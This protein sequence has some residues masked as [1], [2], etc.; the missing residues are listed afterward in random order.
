MQGVYMIAN[1]KG[2][3]LHLDYERLVW[4]TT[5]PG[6]DPMT[7]P[8]RKNAADNLQRRIRIQAYGQNSGSDRMYILQDMRCTPGYDNGYDGYNM[9]ASGQVNIY[10][11]EACGS[12]EVS[13]SNHIDSM[14]IGFCAGPDTT[15]TLRFTSLIGESLYIKDLAN[16]SIIAL[17]ERGEYRFDA[18]AKSVND[19]R[20][21]VLLNP[22]LPNTT[23]NG[24]GVTTDIEDITHTG[25]WITD[26]HICITTGM[27][28]NYA[29]VYNM[30]GQEVMSTRFNNQT[31]LPTYGL[32]TG[33]YIVR[34]NNNVYKF[35]KQD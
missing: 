24:G 5:N 2:C 7:M 16:D 20:F 6:N 31:T 12:M 23:P 22:D 35:V 29:V 9:N 33:V 14:Y 17:S 4:N 26:N 8:G 18:A 30:N 25:M 15:Y 1:Q 21:Q 13:A 11:N 28:D 32:G 10:T 27:T 19:M 34:V 3:Q